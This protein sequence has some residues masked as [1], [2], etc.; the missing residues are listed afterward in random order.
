LDQQGKRAQVFPCFEFQTLGDTLETAGISWKYYAPPEDTPGYNWSAFDAIGHI[1]NTSQW[2][3]H[4]VSDSQFAADAQS[5]KLPAVSWLTPPWNYSEHA[6]A[7]SC[8]GENWTV[9]QLNAV[10]QGPL[11]DTTAIF[12]TWDD[13]GGFYD[14]VPP[15]SIDQFGLGP[16]VPMLIIS[17]YAKPGYVSHT[18]YEFSSVLAFI[19]KRFDLPALTP[20]DEQANDMLDSFDFKQT[21][22][23]PL[24]LQPRSCPEIGPVADFENPSINFSAQRV[25]TTSPP[26]RSKVTNRGTAPLIILHVKTTG[27]FAQT[28]NC[29]HPLPVK[30]SCTF[31]FTFTPTK[32]G[33]RYGS[34]MVTDNTTDGPHF[35]SLSGRGY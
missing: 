16:R 1:R 31:S 10:M 14:H 12:L 6:N 15:P 26:Q 8:D 3:E 23:S 34:V 22:L 27:D 35:F 24:R 20:R 13:F 7:G 17:P 19:E 5:G 28:N 21:P 25:H 2:T 33:H 29:K 4:V 18:Q 30:A 32:A 11:W 9:E